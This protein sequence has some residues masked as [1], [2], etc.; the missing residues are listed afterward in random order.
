MK[1]AAI[2]NPSSGGGRAGRDWASI[3]M[4]LGPDVETRFTKARDDATA[5]ARELLL[6]GFDR[7]I[8]VGGDGTVNEV[9]NGFLDAD[10]PLRPGAELA[11]VP[12]GT[13]GDF[14]RSLGLEGVDDAVA[15]IASGALGI[16]TDA[17]RADFI[18]HR[19]A[20]STR[21]FA[22]LVSF[23]MGGEVAARAKN[24]FQ[25]FG[26][27]AAFLYSTIEVALAYRAKTVRL[28]VDGED[29]GEHS[30]LNIAI[31][32]GRFHGGGMHV[33]PR[34]IL[35]D[36]ALDVT[37]IGAL[38]LVELVRDMPVLYSADIYR[39]PK[40]RQFRGRIVQ[41]ESPETVSIEVD[42]EPLGK[43]P[44]TLTALPGVLR[45]LRR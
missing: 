11:L 6:A 28:A 3:A 44:L 25:A 38:S 39:H 42:G 21:Y 1:T 12:I 13:G 5:I 40:T 36:G 7:V 30:I 41:A 4:G 2:V 24:F 10:R 31:G 45:I 16:S 8:A 17:G 34:A 29:A 35:D 23:G 26:G 33:C 14:R 9:V 27:K 15:L 37:V 18:D 19:G 32:N 22:N 43:L 20:Q